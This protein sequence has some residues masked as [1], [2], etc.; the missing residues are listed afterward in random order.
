[1][2][3][4]DDMNT[5][6]RKIRFCTLWTLQNDAMCCFDGII[7]SHAMLDAIK[8]GVLD[9]VCKLRA[10]ALYNTKY[11]IKTALETVTIVYSS[12][13]KYSLFGTGYGSRSSGTHWL[14]ISI[15]LM[16]TLEKR[17]MIARFIHPISIKVEET[18][19]CLFNEKI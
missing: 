15:P 19:C 8:F 7:L 1:M 14:F 17:A 13:K 16:T 6:I 4:L 5:N 11:H 9:Q 10:T 2:V 18:Y 3:L 12:D